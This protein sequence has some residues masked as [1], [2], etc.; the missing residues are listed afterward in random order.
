[1]LTDGGSIPPSSTNQVNH[2][3]S[4]SGIDLDTSMVS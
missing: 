2:D 3:V 1:V 4:K